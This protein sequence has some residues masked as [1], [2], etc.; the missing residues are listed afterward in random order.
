[1]SWQDIVLAV[2]SVLFCVALVPSLRGTDKPALA[3][4][5]ITGSVLAGF[6][7]VY[8]SLSLWLATV[9]TAVSSGLWWTLA[10]QQ[11]TATPR[12]M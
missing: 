2:G 6:V 1:V 10:W 3:T 4:C 8:A 12:R 11:R 7:A 5:L 9:C